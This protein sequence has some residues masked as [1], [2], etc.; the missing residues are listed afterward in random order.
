MQDIEETTA[1]GGPA[2]AAWDSLANSLGR[3]MSASGYTRKSASRARAALRA[4]AASWVSF[5]SSGFRG[6]ASMDGFDAAVGTLPE[7]Q[8]KDARLLPRLLG[9]LED[10]RAALSAEAAFLF[11]HV[12]PGASAFGFGAERAG[13]QPVGAGLVSAKA[14]KGYVD[15][16]G[17]NSVDDDPI[18]PFDLLIADLPYTVFPETDPELA[19]VIKVAAH[20]ARRAKAVLFRVDWSAADRMGFG[21]AAWEKAVAAALPGWEA[22]SVVLHNQHFVPMEGAELFV[23]AAKSWEGDFRPVL[24]DIEPIDPSSVLSDAPH[25]GWASVPGGITGRRFPKERAGRID[26][27]YPHAPAAAV[28]GSGT[29][30]RMLFPL[31]IMALLGIPERYPVPR[32]RFDAYHLLGESVAVP[33]AERAVRGLLRALGMV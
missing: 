4:L 17:D 31:E 21:P 13:G 26:P 24:A 25:T 16:H 8:R 11:Y 27:H 33:V 2:E 12:N 29:D 3:W 28:V 6:M 20:H 30:A 10:D 7:W 9:F 32:D 19:H 1:V 15:F 14:R 23:A 22:R 5:P 18:A